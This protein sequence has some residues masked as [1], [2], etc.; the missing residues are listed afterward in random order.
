MTDP[1]GAAKAVI[2]AAQAFKQTGVGRVD[3]W[4]KGSR[5]N[6][7]FSTMPGYR[8]IRRQRRACE[9]SCTWLPMRRNRETLYETPREVP[10]EFPLD[11][12]KLRAVFDTILSEGHDVLSET[13]SKAL[14]E[15]YEIPVTQTY[16]ARSA[17]DAV[18]YAA[19]VGYPVALKIFSPD[20]THKTDVGGV[21]L[22]L[23]NAEEVTDAFDRHSESG[24]AT[25]SR[26]AT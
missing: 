21:E 12:E 25:S 11:R 9:R 10:M 1:T 5:R 3:G 8:P 19:R 17:E 7:S 15:A 22:N 24:K 2:D 26:C 6:R 16:V 4:R 18:Q 13:T 20:I 14:L 23:A